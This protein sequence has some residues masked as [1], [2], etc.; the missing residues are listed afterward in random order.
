MVILEASRTMKQELISSNS[1]VMT[2]F[3]PNYPDNIHF[4]IVLQREKLNMEVEKKYPCYPFPTPC[5]IC[6]YIIYI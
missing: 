5:T 3:C 2:K 6:K 1:Y 4:T